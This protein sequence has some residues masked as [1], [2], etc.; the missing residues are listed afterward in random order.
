M[1][2]ALLKGNYFVR[3]FQMGNVFENSIF[4]IFMGIILRCMFFFNS[5]L[6]L[7]IALMV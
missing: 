2:N 5:L 6:V 7:D 3:N 1:G 4:M